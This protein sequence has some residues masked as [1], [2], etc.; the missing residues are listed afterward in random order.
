[1]EQ[2]L[3]HRFLIIVFAVTSL[4]SCSSPEKN[5]E[6]SADSVDMWITSGDRK[7]LLSHS[8]EPL[9]FSSVTTSDAL[10]E[11]DSTQAF[12]EIDGFGYA[13]TGGSALLLRQKLT[14]EQ[15]E[16]ILKEL[17]LQNGN[18][19]G[20]SYLRISVGASDLDERPFTY[21]DQPAGRTDISLS[22]FSLAADTVNLIPVLKEIL[23]LV[24]DLKIMASP[25]SAPSWMK[26]NNS[27][28]GGSL[29]K[30]YYDAYARYFVKYIEGMASE[31]IFIDAITL[32]N[33]P[34]NPHNNPSM[35]MTAEEQA[36]FVKNN[37][38]P[39]FKAK[40]IKTKIVVFDHNCDHPEYPIKILD[41]DG[42]RQYID[43][44]AFHLYLGEIDA[45][46]KVR[47]AHPDKNIYFTEQWTSGKGD[48]GGDLRWHVKNLIVGATRNWS[49]NVLEWNMASDPEFNPHTTD[50]GCT[51]C[52][53]ALTI[54]DSIV[55]NV[56]Y[57]VIGHASK[58]VRPGSFRIASNIIDGLPN[59][60]FIHPS[61]QKVLIVLNDSNEQ[62]TFGI[63][64]K[65]R[66]AQSTVTPGSVATY[67]WK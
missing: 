29:K 6:S 5:T 43:G 50:G 64:F 47:N 60:A 58:F 61:G 48:F 31:G 21:D 35:V 59:V 23:T 27:P 36:N 2:Q 65:G 32:Q 20:I 7:S 52:L 3:N 18:N 37:L 38:G 44:S 4:F 10:I 25:W 11:I 67:S 15:R 33:E 22:D 62:K 12:Q 45:L 63:K 55:R 28:K 41:D 30:E 34:E 13:L 14:P 1:M 24:P 19:I 53:G 26:S 9:V 42:A 17:F 56:S 8:L 40:R 54:G 49:R 16:K 57:Y 51:E 46:S 39:A 66:V